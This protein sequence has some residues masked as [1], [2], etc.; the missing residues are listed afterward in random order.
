M[1][2]I[3]SLFSIRVAD[4]MDKYVINIQYIQAVHYSTL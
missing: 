2:N 1:N 3:I 4:I